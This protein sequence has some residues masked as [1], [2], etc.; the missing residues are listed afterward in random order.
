MYV[1]LKIL[2]ILCVCSLEYSIY[3]SVKYNNGGVNLITSPYTVSKLFNKEEY[4]EGIKC[5]KRNF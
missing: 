1:V 3:L 2:C 4:I 5:N